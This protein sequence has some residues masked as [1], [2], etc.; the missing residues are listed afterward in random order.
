GLG[1]YT[2]VHVKVDG[3]WMISTVRDVA[4]ETPSTYQNHAD[5]E[6]LIGTWTAE[7]H[8]AKLDSVCSW[9]A[10][11][12]FVERRYSL[13]AHD[14]TQTTGVQIIGWNPQAGHVQSWN[15]SSDG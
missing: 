12:S 3:K 7:V 9:I 8:G 15:F 13:T 5:L 10:N 4:I 14:G 6:W 2:A 11:K 1:K